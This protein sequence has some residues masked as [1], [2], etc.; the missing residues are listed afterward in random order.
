MEAPRHPQGASPRG[1]WGAALDLYERI[2]DWVLPPGATSEERWRARISVGLAMGVIAVIFV[3][4]LINLKGAPKIGLATTAMSLLSLAMF[5]LMRKTGSSTLGTHYLAT[6]ALLV[7]FYNAHFKGGLLGSPL[8]WGSS[9]ILACVLTLGHRKA[10]WWTLA[11]SLLPPYFALRHDPDTWPSVYG[12]IWGNALMRI[13]SYWLVFWLA[14]FMER[15]RWDA[16]AALSQ[17][18]QEVALHNRDLRLILDHAE[19]GFAVVDRDGRLR[20]QRSASLARWFGELGPEATLHQLLERVDPALAQRVALR[21][22]EQG[23]SALPDQL[24][25]QER[26]LRLDARPLPEHPDA[27]LLVFT[28]VTSDHMRRDAERAR[29]DLMAL[30][31]LSRDDPQ[32][33]SEFWRRAVTLANPLEQRHQVTDADLAALQRHS[34][35]HGAQHLA[36]QCQ[37]ARDTGQKRQLV[38]AWRRLR[39]QLEAWTEHARRYP[40]RLS[41]E[42][43]RALL[44]M[45]R[46]GAPHGDIARRAQEAFQGTT[47]GVDPP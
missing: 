19:Q 42:D 29:Q 12:P 17:R 31:S 38:R 34:L 7:V 18:E 43:H 11:F 47:A 10:I 46:A 23:L 26:Y 28:D 8:L 5:P 16:Y 14:S 13:G 44:E 41:L 33:F 2:C 35:A 25:H 39:S 36:E 4:G 22:E 40:L 24:Y 32:A 45:A 1:P 15:L 20:R 3:I 6:L 37:R 21:W 30:F 27:A 9:C